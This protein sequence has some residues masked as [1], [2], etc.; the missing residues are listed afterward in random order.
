MK[1]IVSFLRWEFQGCTRSVSLWGAVVVVIGLNMM[2]A[3]C[4]GPW[5]LTVIVVGF[6]MNIVDMLYAWIRFRVSMFKMEQE[7]VARKLKEN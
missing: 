3:G 1:K 7:S 2:A 5:P 6:A 4:P